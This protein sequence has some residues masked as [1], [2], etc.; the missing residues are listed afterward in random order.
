MGSRP[1]QAGR[2]HLLRWNLSR[3]QKKRKKSQD[4]S[5]AGYLSGGTEIDKAVN[6]CWDWGQNTLN[7]LSLLE[8][9]H[10]GPEIGAEEEGKLG[11]FLKELGR[12]G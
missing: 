6:G 9:H 11:V 12:A 5:E 7:I 2:H 10:S 1:S 3:P 8:P 4:S